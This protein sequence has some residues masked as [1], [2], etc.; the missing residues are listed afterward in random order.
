MGAKGKQKTGAR[1]GKG[2]Q[3]KQSAKV[4]ARK[5][6]HFYPDSIPPGMTHEVF[7]VS[8]VDEDGLEVLDDDE[9]VAEASVPTA[10]TLPPRRPSAA[11]HPPRPSVRSKPLAPQQVQLDPLLSYPSNPAAILIDPP[12]NAAPAAPQPRSSWRGWLLVV[13]AAL[14]AL[15][16][17]LLLGVR[18]DRR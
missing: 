16:F 5:R 11:P 17:G 15:L 3:A 9:F 10:S 12:S 8:R 6:H 14:V 4:S 18:R 2:P 7:D 13:G 1:R